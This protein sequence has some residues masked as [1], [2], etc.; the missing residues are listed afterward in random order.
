MDAPSF[1]LP[2]AAT[3]TPGRDVRLDLCRG[4]ALWFIF[5]DHVPNNAFAWLTLRNYGFSDTTE[6]FFFV[7]GYTCMLAY[8]DELA[9]RGWLATLVRTTRRSFEIYVAFLL[10]VL[11]YLALVQ[12]V[13]GDRSLLDASNTAVFFQRPAEAVVRL[14]TMQYMPVN[15]DVLPTFVLL[16]LLFPVLL[17]LLRRAAW[18]TLGASLLLYAL[19]QAT[20]WN[21][22]AWPQNEWFFNPL[23][24]QVLFVFGAWY[25]TLPKRL[26]GDNWWSRA[27]FWLSVAYLVFSFA[28]VISWQV[29][30]IENWLPEI[31]AKLIY[32]VDKSNMAPA[33]LLHF[34]ALL[35]VA[36]ELMKADWRGL[37]TSPIVAIIRCGENSLS[38]YCLGVLLSFLG[39]MALTKVSD[40]LAMQAAISIAGIAI[41]I[42][43]ATLLTWSAK[44]RGGG[45]TLL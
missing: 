6:V 1:R 43:V 3:A 33:R 28:V 23:A 36:A 15:T 4:L 5:L 31:L 11:S 26:L 25:G 9:R 44:R 29:K 27:I 13:G 12:V 14:M 18:A 8:G 38:I 22:P 35:V 42:A 39:G 37:I 20:W 32:P 45:P 17:W 30:A 41:M 10:L 2:T 7:S 24:W 16:H 21:L 34:L 19:V 40:G